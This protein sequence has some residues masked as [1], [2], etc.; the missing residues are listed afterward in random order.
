[1]ENTFTIDVSM[2]MAA[3]SLVGMVVAIMTFNS[4]VKERHA[5]S[6]SDSAFQVCL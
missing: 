2:I 6:A 1:M 3:I 4:A 5:R